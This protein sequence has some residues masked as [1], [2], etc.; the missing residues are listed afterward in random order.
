M[1]RIF[2]TRRS[3]EA[4]FVITNPES[5]KVLQLLTASTL[6]EELE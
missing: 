4:S 5:I 1:I 6:H 3:R 2:R